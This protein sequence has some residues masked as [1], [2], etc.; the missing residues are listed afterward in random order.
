MRELLKSWLIWL[1]IRFGLFKLQ[2]EKHYK[3]GQPKRNYGMINLTQKIKEFLSNL[4]QSTKD[5]SPTWN[6]TWANSLK[7]MITGCRINNKEKV[8]QTTTKKMKPL[9]RKD[10]PEIK[11]K[12]LRILYH[13]KIK[14]KISFIKIL[15]L[16]VVTIINRYSN[17]IKG[18][19]R[20]IP[21]KERCNR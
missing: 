11:E 14:T 15:G 9:T 3:Y 13:R 19:S 5:L 7:L 6:R 10:G 16:V 17:T 1:L 21:T 18:K 8:D 20:S 4:Y 12:T 2:E